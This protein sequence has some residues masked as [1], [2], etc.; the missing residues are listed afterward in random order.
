M[1]H[2]NLYLSTAEWLMAIAI[3]QM[4]FR[5]PVACPEKF[6]W[7]TY[8][9]EMLPATRAPKLHTTVSAAVH[10]AALL[11]SGRSG[12]AMAAAVP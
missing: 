9:P 2:S 11:G 10:I 5:A 1:L 3:R 12:L 4:D 7:S 8:K 6:Q